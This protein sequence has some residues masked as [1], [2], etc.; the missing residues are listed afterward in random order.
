MRILSVFCVLIFSASMVQADLAMPKRP[1]F[2][3]K[4]GQGLANIVLSPAH[5]LDS[6]YELTQE[7]GPT[8]GMSKGLVQGTS[9][10]IMDI[11]IGVAEVVSSP[12]G[13]KSLK[14][15]AYDNLQVEPYPPADLIDNWY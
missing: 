1:N 10:M 14:S 13:G 5:I 7:E 3:D 4:M 15:P 8:V 11:V 9:R 6:T 12:F 2:Y